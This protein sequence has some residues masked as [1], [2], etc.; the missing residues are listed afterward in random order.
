MWRKRQNICENALH[1]YGLWT[2]TPNLLPN[3]SNIGAMDEVK[4]V[5]GPPRSAQLLSRKSGPPST[6]AAHSPNPQNGARLLSALSLSGGE[7]LLATK[8]RA[9]RRL[10]RGA[11]AALLEAAA[12]SEFRGRWA[13]SPPVMVRASRPGG[14][15][16]APRKMRGG[17]NTSPVLHCRCLRK[18][19]GTSSARATDRK[20]LGLRLEACKRTGC[21]CTDV[22]R[23]ADPHPRAHTPAR[24][25]PF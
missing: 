21:G 3:C 4:G 6:E 9:C 20:R 15:R 11:P 5:G 25:H 1:R 12:S 8:A 19:T 7:R 13:A 10:R 17:A 24:T 14:T 16:R 22:T 23:R 2:Q 18:P